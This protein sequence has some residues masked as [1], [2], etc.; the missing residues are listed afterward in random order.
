MTANRTLPWQFLIAAFVLGLLA[1]PA[2]ADYAAAVAAYEKGAYEEAYREFHRLAENGYEE[3]QGYLDEMRERGMTF[4]IEEVTVSKQLPRKRVLS[5]RPPPS[6]AMQSW[7]RDPADTSFELNPRK[8]LQQRVEPLATDIVVPY[9]APIWTKI[10]YLPADA[11]LVGLQYVARWLDADEL[12]RD[13]QIIS[14]HG[15]T[16]TVG[17]LAV[18]WWLLILRALYAGGAFLLSLTRT[19]FTS[20]GKE[21]YG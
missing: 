19:A 15:N 14:E 3:A 5:A 16:I 7:N 12:Y 8:F 11:V 1:S 10:F 4:S 6:R 13:L 20:F 18:V 17:I 2:I 21:K 9:H